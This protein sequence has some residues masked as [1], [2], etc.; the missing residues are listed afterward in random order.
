M[1]ATSNFVQ[2]NGVRLHYLE[3]PGDGRPMVIFHGNSH[4][5]GAWAP[6]AERLA[7]PFRVLAFDL[8]GHGLSDKPETGYDWGSLR[9]DLVA[10]LDTL[11][12]HRTV[13]VGH[14]RGGGMSIL[15]VTAAPER[16]DRL[17]VY[18]PTMPSALARPEGEQSGESVSDQLI[19]RALRR[20]T[21]FSSRQ[22]IYDQY[23]DRDVFRK[24][25][26]EA[27]WAYINHGTVLREDG[28]VE[29][30]CPGWVEAALY[31]AMPQ[32]G[33]W[34]GIS[35]TALPVLAVYGELSG[36]ASPGS[37]PAGALRRIFPQCET[38]VLPGATHFGP[39]EQPEAFA[40][41]VR[42]FAGHA[43]A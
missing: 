38:F 14:S 7:G 37:D 20:R 15:G 42:R 29:L 12:L 4:C 11:D 31:R 26:D 35:N 5:G 6:V 36:R 2:A 30:G 27:L 22:E 3:W 8:P 21:V 34:L 32:T 17:L 25:T 1:E 18:E 24:W 19:E 28:Q 40:E 39:M 23:R 10:I 43:D 16:V 9:D 41:I 33:P 13:V